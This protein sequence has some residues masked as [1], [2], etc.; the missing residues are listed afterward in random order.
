LS[1]PLYQKIAEDFMEKI[2]KGELGPGDR[3]PTEAEL[4]GVYGV[5]RITV[6]HAIR[7]LQNKNL[8]YRVKGSGTFIS[9][10]GTAG[11]VIEGTRPSKGVSFISVIFPRGEH[12]GAHE[13]LIG[14]E[15][16][17][18]KGD[19]Y[20]TIHNSKNKPVLEHKII[21]NLLGQG[22]GGIIVYPCFSDHRNID[23]YSELIIRDFPFVVID[24]RIDLLGVPFVACD[25][26]TAMRELVAFLIAK[27]HTR[28]GFFCN[29]I[30]TMS[31]ERERYKGYCEAHI[32]AGLSVKPGLLFRVT[33]D[34]GGGTEFSEVRE[35]N[36]RQFGEAALAHFL[37]VREKPTCIVA[38]NDIL[39][40][41]LMKAALVQGLRVPADLSITGFDDLYV[42]AH[43][44]VPLTTIRQPFETIGSEAA[45]L[46]LRRIKGEANPTAEIR[47]PGSIVL[48]E[49]AGTAGQGG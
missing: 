21:I 23:V 31:S 37:S 48:R 28:I 41:A 29:S 13:T 16:E 19:F 36:N 40:I 7:V 2:E 12:D 49:S 8:V 32:A 1:T 34:I 33:R 43:V 35:H 27:G 25:N 38:V 39:A 44:E 9:K 26:E 20:V 47:I 30:E 24:R 5:S 17:C 46:L 45:R 4:G 10:R 22:C 18:A 42:A 6:T 3:M 14:I 15:S 11:S